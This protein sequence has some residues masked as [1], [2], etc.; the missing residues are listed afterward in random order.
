MRA[1]CHFEGG[2]GYTAGTVGRWMRRRRRWLD[3]THSRTNVFPNDLHPNL[4]SCIQKILIR[5]SARMTVALS[6]L[7]CFLQPDSLTVSR[8]AHDRLLPVPFQSSPISPTVTQRRFHSDPHGVDKQSTATPL[9]LCCVAARFVR[10]L[11]SS[12]RP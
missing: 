1:V 4:L 3:M 11:G 5:A 9:L 8:A 2:A 6:V 12:V 10:E 7:F